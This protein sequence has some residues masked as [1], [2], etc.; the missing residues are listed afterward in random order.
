MSWISLV[1]RRPRPALLVLTLIL[2]AAMAGL[3]LWQLDRAAQK[4]ALLNQHQKKSGLP[5][6]TL[7]GAD[8]DREAML[9]RKVRLSGEMDLAHQVLLDNRKHR[10]QP[11]YLVFAPLRLPGSAHWVLVARGWIYQGKDRDRLPSLPGSGG[12]VHLEGRVGTVPSVGMKLGPPSA[13]SEWPRR[14]TYL[15]LDWLEAQLGIDL[16]DYVVFQSGPDEGALVRDWPS[17]PQSQSRMPPERHV[18]Y[19]VQWFAMAAVLLVIFAALH[20]RRRGHRDTTE[21]KQ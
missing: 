6:A 21:L 16:M 18:A 15:D 20:L 12:P 2:V 9:Y 11:G 19:A 3:G 13:G 10:G 4:S 8:T 1:F 17:L 5:P 7:D 14:V